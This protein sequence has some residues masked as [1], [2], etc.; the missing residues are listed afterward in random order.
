MKILKWVLIV[1]VVLAAI[2]V[3]GGM[4]MPSAYKVE[5]STLVNV[6]PAKVYPLIA[7]PRSWPK[8][9]VWN[10]RDPGMKLVF[11]GAPS[12]AGAKWSWESKSEGNG[13]ME[14]T[15]AQP[16]KSITYALAFPD[17]GMASTGQLA[18]AP[19]GNGT[20]VRWTNAGDVGKNPL[21]R[22]FVPFMDS[23]MG[24][25]FEG[26]LANLKALAEKP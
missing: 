3:A 13:N 16:D 18:L 22:W 2:V 26:G 25:D 15:A 10:K 5:R 23:M 17:M 11:A 1:V 8:W 21:M 9:T 12:G 7:E 20:R 4:L 19:E 6:P 14:F 24:P